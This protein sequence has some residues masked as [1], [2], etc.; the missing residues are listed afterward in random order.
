[1]VIR[2]SSLDRCTLIGTS[3]ETTCTVHSSEPSTKR[4]RV[5]SSYVAGKKAGQVEVK[6]A[7]ERVLTRT[8]ALTSTTG[9]QAD[10]VIRVYNGLA[11]TD[12][13]ENR[14]RTPHPRVR[15][16]QVREVVPAIMAQDDRYR[17][18]VHTA[19]ISN[20]RAKGMKIDIE[21]SPFSPDV[22]L[23]VSNLQYE[24][25]VSQTHVLSVKLHLQ[26]E[27]L[28]LRL[29]SMALEVTMHSTLEQ[30]FTHLLNF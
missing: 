13:S 12:N 23:T 21:G 3:N 1:M 15:H 26:T 19:S 7:V 27:L 25:W 9:A 22:C 2:F 8:L 4:P 11:R 28:R 17:H 18:Y 30:T 20:E 14:S 5:E 24:G 16:D 29:P 6:E 10:R